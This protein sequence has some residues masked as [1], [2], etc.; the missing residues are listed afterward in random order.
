MLGHDDARAV[1]YQ[2][3]DQV[4]ADHAVAAGARGAMFS[5]V[6]CLRENSAPIE[7]VRRAE[8]ISI[9]LHKLEWALQQEDVPRVSAA[10]DELKML[11]VNWLDS[12]IGN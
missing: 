12:R 11:A 3:L 8:Q 7:E 10:L 6:D 5:V 1:A 9:E 2:V 4:M